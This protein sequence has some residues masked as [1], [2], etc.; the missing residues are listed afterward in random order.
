MT[1]E[2]AIEHCKDVEKEKRYESERSAEHECL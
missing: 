1:L 2:E